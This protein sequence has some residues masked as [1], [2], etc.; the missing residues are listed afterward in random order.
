[1]LRH[2]ASAAARAETALIPVSSMLTLIQGLHAIGQAG[3]HGHQLAE[4]RNFIS[5]FFEMFISG[6]ANHD[7]PLEVAREHATRYVGWVNRLK[8]QGATL[9]DDDARERLRAKLAA[10]FEGVRAAD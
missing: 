9:K 1:Q 8:Q 5:G 2:A 3:L 4:R 10:Y 6:L 7:K